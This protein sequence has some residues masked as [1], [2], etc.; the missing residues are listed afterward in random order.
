[1]SFSHCYWWDYCLWKGRADMED[2]NAW[3]IG[4]E[5]VQK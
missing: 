5:G 2:Y 4:C 1:M 3:K